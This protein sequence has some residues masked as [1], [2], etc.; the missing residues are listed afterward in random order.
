MEKVVKISLSDY[1]ILHHSAL[2]RS[3]DVIEENKIF[4][5]PYVI[6]PFCKEKIDLENSL[7]RLDTEYQCK[8]ELKTFFISSKP[9]S[10]G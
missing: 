10:E 2:H 9:T 8:K 1:K 4:L 7:L 3:L 5:S 6:C